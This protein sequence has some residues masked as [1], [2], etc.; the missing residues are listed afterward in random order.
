MQ[1]VV[2]R[3][4]DNIAIVLI[5]PGEQR[6]EIPLENLPEGTE[7]SSVLRVTFELD[8]VE[9]ERM[10]EDMRERIER[11]KKGTRRRPN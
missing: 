11:L 8:S 6:L 2:D 1:A 3:I 10:L 7:E 4:E 9:T 5:E